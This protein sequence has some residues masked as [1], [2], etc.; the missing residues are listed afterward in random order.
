MDASA[1]SAPASDAGGVTSTQGSTTTESRPGSTATSDD[2][3][4]SG[5]TTSTDGRR[6][7]ESTESTDSTEGGATSS[8]SG[9]RVDGASNYSGTMAADC[10]IGLL[11]GSLTFSVD[12]DG[13]VD[14]SASI[15]LGAG[16]PFVAAVSGS[17]DETGAVDASATIGG[18]LG[19]CSVTGTLFDTGS[20][21]CVFS[22]PAAVCDGTWT[23]SAD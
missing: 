7:D 12:T 14:G 6:D 9:E 11:S 4:T 17:V 18:P 5:A 8:T 22:C 1:S 20:G 13:V 3:S 21:S 2:S 10:L 15:S 23:V 16:A 19:A